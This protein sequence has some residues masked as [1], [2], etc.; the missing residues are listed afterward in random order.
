M[1]L[2]IMTSGLV[3][4]GRRVVIILVSP[5]PY[6]L[7]MIAEGGVDDKEIEE[8]LCCKA[9]GGAGESSLNGM[10]DASP[11][12]SS[13]AVFIFFTCCPLVGWLHFVPLIVVEIIMCI[14]IL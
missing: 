8:F 5:R 12:I 14:E 13:N 11:I 7:I 10:G 3:W 4:R 1:L 2:S 9:D 6:F